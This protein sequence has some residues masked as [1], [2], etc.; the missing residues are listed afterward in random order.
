MT[1]VALRCS[2][3]STHR[4]PEEYHTVSFFM[5]T[6]SISPT[7]TM[8]HH[9]AAEADF[10]KAGKES[11]AITAI[12]AT[13]DKKTTWHL[14]TAEDQAAVRRFL[15]AYPFAPWFTIESVTEVTALA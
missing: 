15:A 6:V 2:S 10:V 14:V 7:A 3:N 11:G 9:A 8:Q 13:P 1:G 4:S 5:A 12:Y